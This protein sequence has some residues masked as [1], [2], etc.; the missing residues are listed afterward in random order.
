MSEELA[1]DVALEAAFDVTVGFLLGSP[2]VGVGLGDGV[3]TEPVPNHD[4]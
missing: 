2:A 4:V 1:G 3:V